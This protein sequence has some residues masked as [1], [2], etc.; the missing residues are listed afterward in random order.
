MGP[1]AVYNNEMA[2]VR[3]L[4]YKYFCGGN[5]LGAHFCFD[6]L[7]CKRSVV[8]TLTIT[9]GMCDKLGNLFYQLE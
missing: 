4:F 7:S 3:L 8:L 5:C 2:R 6:V 9:K 1:G